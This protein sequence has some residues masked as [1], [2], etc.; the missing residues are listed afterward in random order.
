MSINH[1]LGILVIAAA[2]GFTWYLLV[3]STK[4]VKMIDREDLKHMREIKSRLKSKDLGGK[5]Q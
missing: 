1:V 2:Y 4:I 5:E 3:K